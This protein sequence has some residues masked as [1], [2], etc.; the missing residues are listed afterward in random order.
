[1]SVAPTP[2]RHSSVY[3]LTGLER[4]L[5][6]PHDPTGTSHD[7]PASAHQGRVIGREGL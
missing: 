5:N 1:M 2:N 4:P 3:L 7:G 6:D